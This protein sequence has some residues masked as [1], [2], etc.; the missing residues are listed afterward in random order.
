VDEKIIKV[1]ENGRQHAISTNLDTIGANKLGLN[2][3]HVTTSKEHIHL[4]EFVPK[5]S[6]FFQEKVY[7][8]GLD[9]YHQGKEDKRAGV[10]FDSLVEGTPSIQIC[11][12]GNGI[13]TGT[14]GLYVVGEIF[15]VSN[16]DIATGIDSA[17]RRYTDIHTFALAKMLV[18]PNEEIFEAIVAPREVQSIW[19]T[20]DCDEDKRETAQRL[21]IKYQLPI[22]VLEPNKAGDDSK[23]RRLRE[24]IKN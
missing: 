13:Y 15:V 12:S 14:I 19:I 4:D 3:E 8:H 1:P 24:V 5:P 6:Q 23:I 2:T 20:T 18:D 17:N 16:R 21:S 22:V 10:I 9:A 11:C 7:A